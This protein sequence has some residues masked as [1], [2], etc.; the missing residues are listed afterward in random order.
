M[1]IKKLPETELEVMLAVWDSELPVSTSDIHKYLEKQRSWNMSALQTVLG[2][3]T[4]KGFLSTEKSGKNRYFNCLISKDDYLAQ[5]NRLLLKR[6]NGGN[7]TALV[8]SLYDS[9]GITD[10]DLEDL[11]R[12]INEKTGGNKNG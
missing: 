1:K 12:Y 9:K 2:R 4:E 6:L 10:S 11:M 5:E 8:A 7:L 3:L